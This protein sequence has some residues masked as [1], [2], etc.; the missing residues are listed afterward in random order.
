MSE[1]S[2]Y[3]ECPEHHCH[4]SDCFDLHY[5]QAN[6]GS[7]QSP[8]RHQAT[9]EFVHQGL[10]EGWLERDEEGNLIDE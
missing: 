7:P 2:R 5:P 6:T 1:R 4:M 3:V 9:I 8:Q 10:Q